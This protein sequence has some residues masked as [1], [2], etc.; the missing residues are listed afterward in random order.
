MCDNYL[1]KRLN[2]R[3]SCNHANIV[4][5]E[6]MSRLFQLPHIPSH[7][8]IENIVAIFICSVSVLGIDLHICQ[9]S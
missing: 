2:V 8:M 5:T 4:K 6:P 7:Y 9:M 3:N 1:L